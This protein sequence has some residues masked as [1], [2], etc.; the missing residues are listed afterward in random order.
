MENASKALLIAGEVL[1]GILIMTVGVYFFKRLSAEGARI[2]IQ[3]E[4]DKQS[5]FNQ[6][7]LK[8]D[9]SNRNYE[10]NNGSKEEAYL[11]IQDVVSVINIAKENNQQNGFNEEDPDNKPSDIDNSIYVQV[12]MVVES[13]GSRQRTNNMEKKSA[14]DI[15]QILRENMHNVSGYENLNKYQCTVK[16]NQKTGYVN[17]I[18]I[19]EK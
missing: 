7:F 6:R 1:I 12:N 15:I 13:D 18:E 9:T 17:L 19:E 8:Y 3:M 14:N 4:Y 5:E 2:Y 16:I 11:N 10:F